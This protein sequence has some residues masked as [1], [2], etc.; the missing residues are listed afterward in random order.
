MREHTL[1]RDEGMRLDGNA[2]GR[3]VSCREGILWVT[4]T[5]T[6]GDHLL[7]A[8]ETFSSDRPG[9]LVVGALADSIFTVAE[10]TSAPALS[11]GMF[12]QVLQRMIRRAGVARRRLWA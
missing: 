6:P 1:R 11:P 8:G 7:R 2:A 4:Q 3:V 9:R 12:S 5:G 10:V